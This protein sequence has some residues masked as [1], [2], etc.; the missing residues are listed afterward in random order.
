MC[1]GTGIAAN[2]AWHA[3][4]SHPKLLFVGTRE[5]SVLR[6]TALQELL[7]IIESMDGAAGESVD[8]FTFRFRI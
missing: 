1:I 6:L 5:G 4:V 7:A 8:C 2:F 3:K